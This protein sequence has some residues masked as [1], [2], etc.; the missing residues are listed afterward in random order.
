[1][2]GRGREQTG[3]AGFACQVIARDVHVDRGTRQSA[4]AEDGCPN[5][6]VRSGCC[7][8]GLPSSWLPCPRDITAE[9]TGYRRDCLCVAG[10]CAGWLVAAYL[11]G[12]AAPGRLDAATSSAS[13]RMATWS[14]TGMCRDHPAG[15]QPTTTP[16]SDRHLAVAVRRGSPPG[17]A[18][19]GPTPSTCRTRA[20]DAP[21]AR[22]TGR[23]AVVIRG[24]RSEP[25]RLQRRPRPRG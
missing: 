12:S 1:M 2:S 10:V 24:R 20:R 6:G 16:R 13:T 25:G 22:V 4:A 11:L 5:G 8:R 7:E 15:G 9:V 19:R 14:S 3:A 23:C 21:A 17:M 18:V